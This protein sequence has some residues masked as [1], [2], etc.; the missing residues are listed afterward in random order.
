MGGN[1]MDMNIMEIYS[2]KSINEKYVDEVFNI[3]SKISSIQIF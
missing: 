3:L 2:I 1:L